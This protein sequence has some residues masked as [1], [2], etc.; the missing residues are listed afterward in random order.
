MNK[1]LS[2][3]EHDN[4]E[5]HSSSKLWKEILRF[6]S[7][8]GDRYFSLTHN[9]IKLK[10]FVG[11]IQ[12]NSASIEILP[13][14]DRESDRS[15]RSIL[16]DILIETNPL[17]LNTSGLSHQ[18]LRSSSFLDYY[19]LLFLNH[20]EEIIRNGLKKRYGLVKI[21]SET[22]KGKILFSETFKKN[23]PFLHRHV[24]EKIDYNIDNEENQI[25][26]LTLKIISKFSRSQSIVEHSKQLYNQLDKVSD[27]TLLKVDFNRLFK[28]PLTDNY[29][30]TLKLSQ[31][32]ISGFLPELTSGSNESISILFDMNKLFETLVLKRLQRISNTIDGME[33]FGSKGNSKRFWRGKLI[34]PDIIIKYKKSTFILDTKWKVPTPFVPSDND[35]KQMF[36]YGL[37][38]ESYLNVLVY[39]NTINSNQEQNP[40]EGAFNN[41]DLATFPIDLINEGRLSNSFGNKIIQYLVKSEISTSSIIK[42]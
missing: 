27:I 33:V 12:F 1:V 13:K 15:I 24:Q 30:D 7:K 28:K 38:Y 40:F 42:E 29:K 32:I 17:K 5:I 36:V 2:V 25:L 14:I 26:K 41:Y 4:L 20:S 22:V 39:P 8:N 23:A 11:I 9:G 6:Y 35:I 10:Q 3:F 21:N 37:Y 31:I 34:K 18:Q 16:L 19:F